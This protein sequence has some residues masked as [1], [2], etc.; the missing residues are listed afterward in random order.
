MAD[1]KEKTIYG[2]QGGEGSFNEQAILHY[3]KESKLENY[4]I[5]YLF[6]SQNV[7]DALLN[8]TINVGQ[9]A[10]HNTLGGAVKESAAVLNSGAITVVNEFPL[11]IQHAL[12]AHNDAE[13]ETLEK[14]MAHPQ[15][16]AQCKAKLQ[17]IY[18]Q[19]ATM[20]GEGDLIDPAK[21]AQHIATSKLHKNVAVLGNAS[22]AAKHG[23]KIVHSD[24]QDSADNYTTFVHIIKQSKQ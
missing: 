19:L 1:I 23:L 24:L 9:M 16:L 5:V 15:A 18:P 20:S 7:L 6:T 14:V 13:L 3:I 12:M 8:G 11:K 17:K 2:I 4:E 22:L 10:T 21:V